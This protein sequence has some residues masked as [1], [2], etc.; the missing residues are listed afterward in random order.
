MD[1]LSSRVPGTGAILAAAAMGA[2]EDALDG[3]PIANLLDRCLEVDGQRGAVDRRAHNIVD[4]LLAQWTA[5]IERD[6]ERFPDATIDVMRSIRQRMVDAR[7]ALLRVRAMLQGSQPGSLAHADCSRSERF[8]GDAQVEAIPFS[9]QPD[10]TWSEAL[11]GLEGE[12]AAH[13]FFRGPPP[14]AIGAATAPTTAARSRIA[15]IPD[16]R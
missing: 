2:F 1:E 5:T 16:A 7:D 6:L 11:L 9:G 8:P 13:G 14:G 12:G 15:P 3:F 4:H 10:S